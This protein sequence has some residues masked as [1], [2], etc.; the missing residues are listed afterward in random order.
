MGICSHRFRDLPISDANGYHVPIFMANTPWD[1]F[2]KASIT[3]I[4]NEKKSL[5][6]IGGGLRV[7]KDKNNRYD[8][9]NNWIIPLIEKVD[10]KVLDPVADYHPDIIGDIH[11]LPFANNSQDAITCIAVLEHVKNP[12][13]AVEEMYRVLKP[14]GY[15]YVF[16]PFLY[17]YHPMKG[18][19]ADYW[20]FTRDGVN[21]L[22]K[23]FSKTEIQN[24]RGAIE[25]ASHLAPF[26]KNSIFSKTMQAMDR[27]MKK[28]SSNQTS[29]F[30]VF[31]VK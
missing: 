30:N 29:G 5:I 27:L 24:V 1:S 15:C 13:K 6:D 28:I 12:F 9:K 11:D 19:Y 20:R 14:G 16:V 31:L 25:T 17:Y 3:R 4:L 7:A 2:F 23:D 8:P 26:G 21:E 10:Y 22:F 18:Y